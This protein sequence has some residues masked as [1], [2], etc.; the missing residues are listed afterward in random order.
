MP[1]TSPTTGIHP[2]YVVYMVSAVADIHS[3]AAV[4]RAVLGGAYQVDMSTGHRPNGEYI[5]TKGPPN[6]AR[7]C[8]NAESCGLGGAA[9]SVL[10]Y[11]IA[12]LHHRILFLTSDGLWDYLNVVPM[13]ITG[14]IIGTSALSGM[15]KS[16]G[17]MP[18]TNQP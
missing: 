17:M 18:G 14:T 16:M 11:F 10:Q 2:F 12:P 15:A 13:R 5:I 9:S 1:S 6:Q 4:A 8:P 3:S 7:L